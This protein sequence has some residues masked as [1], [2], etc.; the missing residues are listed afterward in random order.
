MSSRLLLPV[1]VASLLCAALLGPHPAEAAVRV[2]HGT[3]VGDGGLGRVVTGLGFRPDVVIVGNDGGLGT[4]IRTATMPAGVSKPLGPANGVQADRILSLDADGFTLGSDGSVND[5]GVSYYWVA[6]E[7][8]PGRME[9]GSYLGDG[10]DNRVVDIGLAPQYLLVL[11]E[12]SEQAMQ[13]FADEVGDASLELQ[14]TGEKSDRIQ[15]FGPTFFEIGK[16]PT[17]NKSGRRYHW[18]AWASAPVTQAVGSYVGDGNPARLVGV[19]PFGP[20]LVFVKGASASE[21]NALRTPEM[22]GTTSLDVAPGALVD[23][24][25]TGLVP[26][27]FLVGDAAWAN[28][29][30]KTIHWLAMRDAPPADLDLTLAVDE[31]TP[32]EGDTILFDLQM[33]NRGPETATS[34]DVAITLPPGLNPVTAAATSGSFD[35]PSG[36]WTLSSVA[37]GGLEQVQLGVEVASFTAGQTLVT[38]AAVQALDQRDPVADNDA[39]AD[40]VVVASEADLLVTVDFVPAAADEGDTV[41]IQARVTNQGP[42]LATNVLA[43]V[44][45]PEQLQYIADTS[46]VGFYDSGF[47]IWL[48]GGLRPGESANLVLQARVR[49]GTAGS[50]VDETVVGGADQPD[51]D[52]A[53]NTDTAQLVLQSADLRLSIASDRGLANVGETVGWAVILHNAGP[54]TAATARVDLSW[55]AGLDLDSALPGQGLFDSTT[56]VWT[57]GAIAPGDSAR[58]DLGTAVLDGSEGNTLFLAGTSSAAQPDP[59]PADASA[60]G[61]VR[62]PLTALSLTASS[63][64]A[65]ARTG[66]LV[67]L[68]LRVRNDGPDA[69]TNAAVTLTLPAGLAVETAAVD[70]GVWDAATT[71]W[72][73]GPAAVSDTHDL[74]LGLRV[75]PGQAG[76]T[77]VTTAAVN[78][79]EADAD[80][81]D[82]VATWSL[83]IEAVDLALTKTVD[84]V[85]PNE[86]EVITYTI[87][88]ENLGPDDATGVAVADTLPPGTSF[89]SAI[90]SQGAYDAPTGIWTVGGLA[91]GSTASLALIARV[92]TGT[93]GTT[94]VNTAWRSASDQDDLDAANDRA[95]VAITVFSADLA[96]DQTVDSDSPNE[97]DPVAFTIRIT[98]LGP[99]AVGGVAVLD[100]LPAGLGFSGAVA[101]VGSYDAPSGVWTVGGLASAAVE[102]LVLQATVASGTAGTTLVNTAAIT[103]SSLPDPVAANDVASVAITVFSADLALDLR[104]S[105]PRPDEGDT[106]AFTLRLD[107]RG[108][109]PVGSVLVA[110]SLAT[111]NTRVAATPSSGSFDPVTGNWSLGALAPGAS[112]SLMVDVLVG[113]GTAGKTLHHV[114]RVLSSDLVDPVAGNDRA[115]APLFVRA[116]D[117]ALVLAGPGVPVNEAEIATWTVDLSNA[118]PDTAGANSVVITLPPGLTYDAAIPS[119]GSFDAPTTTWSLTDLPPDSTAQLILDTRVATG[120]AGSLLAV[121]ATTVASDPVDPDPGNDTATASVRVRAADLVLSKGVDRSSAAI[122]DT[123]TFTLMMANR[124]PDTANAIVVFDSLSMD[125]EYVDHRT[126]A[127]TYDPALGR[128]S[129]AA[130]SPGS[131][132]D[133]EIDARIAAGTSGRTVWNRARILSSV[134]ADPLPIDRADS[135]AVTVLGSDLSMSVDTLP[136]GAAEGDTVETLFRLKNR[137]PADASGLTGDFVV[138]SGLELVGATVTG[139]TFDGVTAQWILP[140]LASGATSI[141][142]ARTR[143]VPGVGLAERTLTARALGLDQADPD[144]TNDGADAV[145]PV[146]LPVGELRVSV[147]Q[148]PGTLVPGADPQTILTLRIENA[149]VRDDTLRAVRLL[150]ASTVAGGAAERDASWAGFALSDAGPA[151]S[152]KTYVATMA[153]GRLVFPDVVFAVPAGETIDL[154]VTGAASIQ[155]RDGDTLD[156]RLAAAGDLEFATGTAPVAAGEI[157]PAGAF[158]VDGMSVAQ[159]LVFDLPVAGLLTGTPRQLVMSFL[160]PPNGYEP[161]V[162]QK[163]NLVDRGTARPTVGSSIGDVAAMEA[164]GDDGDGI[165]DPDRDPRL[166]NFAFTGDRWEITGLSAPVPLS[167]RRIWVSVDIEPTAETG[168]SLELQIPGPPDPGLGMASGNDGPVDRAPAPIPPRSIVAADRVTVSAASADT[169]AVAPGQSGVRLLDLVLSNSYATTRTLSSLV[170]D[171]ATVGAGTIAE[172]D[173]LFQSLTLRLDADGDG[174]ISDLV[175]DPILGVASFTGGSVEF[176]GLSL[177]VP[178]GDGVRLFV[179]ADLDLAATDGDRVAVSVAGAASIGFAEATAVAGAWPVNGPARRIDG[180]ILAQI[181]SGPVPSLTLGASEGPALALDLDIP[182]NGYRADLLRGLTVE[183]VGTATSADLTELRLWRDGGNALFDAGG[184]DDLDLGPLTDLGTVWQTPLLAEALDPASSHRFYVS[185]TVASAP[186]DSSTLRLRVPSAGIDV[187]S[188]NDGPRDGALVSPGEILLSSAPLL[189]SLEF[190]R[191]QSVVGQSVLVRMLVRNVGGESI[192]SITPSALVIEGTGAL[193]LQSGPAP[194]SFD[195]APAAADTFVWTLDAV[196]AGVSSVRASASGVGDS[197]G[198]T[199]QA[200]EAAS[201]AHGV[202]LESTDVDLYAVAASPTTI[203]RG[204]TRYVPLSFTLDHGGDDQRSDVHLD[205]LR[206]RVEDASSLPVDVA[207]LLSGARVVEGTKV[208]GAITSFS[209]G[210][211]LLDFVFSPPVSVTTREP[212]TLAVELAISSTTTVSGFH[213]VLGDSTDID[214]T[215]AISG[216]PVDVLLQ[217]GSYPVRSGWATV[218]AEV[219]E[220]RLSATSPVERRT[221]PGT[222]AVAVLDL[223]AENPGTDGLVADVQVEQLQLR[224]HAGPGGA[225]VDADSLWNRV[226]V[227]AGAQVHADRAVTAADDSLLVVDLSPPVVVAVGAPVDLVVEADLLVG[228][229]PQV[230]VVD[231][232]AAGVRALD[233]GRGVPVPVIATPDPLAGPV[234]RVEDPAEEVMASRLAGWSASTLVGET[235]VRALQMRI[236]HPGAAGTG[237][238]RVDSLRVHLRDEAR[239]PVDAAGVLDRLSVAREDSVLR[240]RTDFDGTGSIVALDLGGLVMEA[241]EIADLWVDVDIEATAPE[242]FLE[243]QIGEDD[244]VVTADVDGSPVAV[245]PDAGTELPLLSGLTRL[246]A[247]A[248]E[249]R[250]DFDDRL[251]AVLA[252]GQ[253]AVPVAD[254][255]L[256]NPAPPGA[257]AIA[258]EALRLDWMDGTGAAV[259][260]ATALRALRLRDGKVAVAGVDSVLA[261]STAVT[262]VLSTP[263]EVAAGASKTLRIEAD[264]GVQPGTASIAARL[265]GDGVA[266]VQPSSA[267]L[268][269]AVL[270]A[271]GR[272]FPFS[273]AAGTFTPGEFS[274]SYSN[275]PN[276][277]AA[278]REQTTFVYFLDED[279]EV[280]LRIHTITGERVRTLVDGEPRAAGLQQGDVWDGRNGRGDVV[281]NGVY[282]ARIVVR[283]AGGGTREEIRKVAVRR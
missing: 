273:T 17:V 144:S 154:E 283:T 159:L 246:Q 132:V 208:Y 239:N 89:V 26:T 110:D 210:D 73:L 179:E 3:Y 53:N 229:S 135:A 190:E 140:A 85:A 176:G 279:A 91:A 8:S 236:R 64:F 72:A 62:V 9:I 249:L 174:T 226:V 193:T 136:S 99:N 172:K 30:G 46:S 67:D 251:P 270:A 55:A 213:V 240:T 13:R 250:V 256:S 69:S 71:T 74:L 88:L 234:V 165:F 195:L 128:W 188:D 196:A 216:G 192:S 52:T 187:E 90:P 58:L 230:F 126:T 61:Q 225:G 206:L 147:L 131:P 280:T 157:D 163:M 107:N 181:G 108:P 41:E 120:T 37:A 6:L 231:S 29:A 4:Q 235:G 219:S 92:D 202:L 263:L 86:N 248:R 87:T 94:I 139:G 175:S 212:V 209:A 272:T 180:M 233:A 2:A 158:P 267:L 228:V 77:L 83:P 34:I 1:A 164:W 12:G 151:P 265:A 255:V 129:V 97:G 243:L 252:A 39:A 134:E 156:L 237:A 222:T 123:V 166:G 168:R 27:G 211:S 143:I 44:P 63:S 155:A 82:N 18:V 247:P 54:D 102:S 35:I 198:L 261:D 142:S 121:G 244:L 220:L 242:A 101:S 109:N 25:I 221:A 275:F 268:N 197:S 145:I 115:T 68:R 98:N 232:P 65:S 47:E 204:Q 66:D 215:D 194:S 59:T 22:P 185:A 201:G 238:V 141:L 14:P 214:A 277:F 45:I 60:L 149:T 7:G 20:E 207:D 31:P 138:G 162:L 84:R 227:R 150:D 223:R 33:Q 103:S 218:R 127:G 93:A 282:L 133:L 171:D 253:T 205:R 262:L 173:G 57:V 16:N 76:Q 276:P 271:A 274:A 152:G 75:L 119:R 153:A 257:T 79:P 38:T 191:P 189:V 56:G 49:A 42:A 50:V 106:V 148:S 32:A 43:S 186:T 160:V 266:V 105:D 118:G 146:D 11:S 81:A 114:G 241:G 177:A 178:A 23:Q 80:S 104:A 169:S 260:A 137:G 100:A 281:R 36:R 167:G 125:F 70:Q 51:P 183:N 182:A 203:G 48:I 161:D 5:P 95:E 200:L 170:I 124:G 15:A 10:K 112:E 245:R 184:G 224:L 258:L 264:W 130:L 113:A 96:L 254:V 19:V 28:E 116:A 217:E 269:I 40:T 122:G 78:G 259:E 21:G 24:A 199:R 117:R 278:G 111:G